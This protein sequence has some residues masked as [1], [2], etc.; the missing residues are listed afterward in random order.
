MVKI[1]P[2][3]AIRP[4]RN[5]VGLFASRSYLTYTK[6]NL[7]EKLENNPYTFL[8]I[9][10]PDYDSK[11]KVTFKEKLEKVKNKYLKFIKENI[12]TQDNNESLYIYQQET[13]DQKYIGIIACVS[14]EDYIKKNI[15][16]HEETITN[17]E[18]KI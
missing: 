6:A 10:N 12:L 3:R 15:K 16:V 11:K 13:L 8:H 7:K 4:K 17:R 14:V 5:L 9:I 1:K 2:F 18:K